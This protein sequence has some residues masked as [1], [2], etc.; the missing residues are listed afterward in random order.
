M[1]GLSLSEQW[2]GSVEGRVGGVG[3][4]EGG[5]TVIRMQ[6]EKTLTFKTKTSPPQ[7]LKD[8]LPK[9]SSILLSYQ[10]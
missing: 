1:E 3:K 9:F 2:M 8:Y 6:N 5:G 7:A 4:E 10:Q